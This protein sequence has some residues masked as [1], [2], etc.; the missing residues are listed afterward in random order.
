MSTSKLITR[1]DLRTIL[2]D[3]VPIMETSIVNEAEDIV[4]TVAPN[5]VEDYVSSSSF[6]SAILD[7]FY[8][9]GCYFETSDSTFNPN[10][11]WGG[12]W[13]AVTK[14]NPVYNSANPVTLAAG[15][16]NL[17]TTV[18]LDAG[19]RYLVVGSAGTGQA[20]SMTSN[21]EI[22]LVS[23]TA[24]VRKFIINSVTVNSGGH[25]VAMAD[26]MTTTACTVGIRKYN[27]TSSA[28]TTGSGHLSAI[29]LTDYNDGKYKWHRTA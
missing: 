16:D 28:I 17:I 18:S 21:A 26:V 12:T 14:H 9:V 13:E 8:P 20:G 1:N 23:G 19:V 6:T 25:L 10:T 22:S 11:S 2:N 29:P 5:I 7:V 27:Y 4:E 3:V 15:S 24:T